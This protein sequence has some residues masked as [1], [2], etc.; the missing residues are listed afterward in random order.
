MNWSMMYLSSSI[1]C[2]DRQSPKGTIGMAYHDY[3]KSLI[4][5][6]QGPKSTCKAAC[7]GTEAIEE[8]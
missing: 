4:L 6:L 7:A 8:T 5:C 2:V 1:L 3:V